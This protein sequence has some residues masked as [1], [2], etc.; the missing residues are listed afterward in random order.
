V[1][2]A[3]AGAA[4]TKTP[5]AADGDL[6]RLVVERLNRARARPVLREGVEE[7]TQI[8]ARGMPSVMLRFTRP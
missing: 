7:V 3:L 2:E 5:A 4:P 1:W 6:W 8:S